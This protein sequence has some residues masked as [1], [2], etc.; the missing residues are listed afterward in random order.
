[1]TA[2]PASFTALA[3]VAWLF[4]GC[5]VIQ[6]FLA[7]LGVFDSPQRFLTHRDFGY[8]FGWL[9]LVALLIAAIGRL[10]RR[11]IGL[12]GLTLV[13]MALQSILIL[14][15]E[16]APALAALHPVNG[17][18]LLVTTLVLGRLAWRG[19]QTV[20]SVA[21]TTATAANAANEANTADRAGAL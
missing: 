3:V 20:A 21:A 1:M 15:R 11:L 14:F 2:R 18:L 6:V 4:A 13:Q 19:P 12:A 8:L 7:G 16:D 10:P 17:V 9:S 5:I